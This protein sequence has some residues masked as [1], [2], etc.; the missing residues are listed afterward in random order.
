MC[1]LCVREREKER[2]REGEEMWGTEELQLDGDYLGR[3]R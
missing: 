3:Y 1:T 2:G